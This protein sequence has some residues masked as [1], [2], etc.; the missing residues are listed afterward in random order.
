[1]NN[2]EISIIIGLFLAVLI[3]IDLENIDLLR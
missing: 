1:M 3:L 2:L